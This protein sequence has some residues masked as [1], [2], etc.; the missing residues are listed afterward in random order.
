M[1]FFDLMFD[2]VEG[3]VRKEKEERRRASYRNYGVSSESTE[4]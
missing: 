1:S 4:A 2:G 3:K